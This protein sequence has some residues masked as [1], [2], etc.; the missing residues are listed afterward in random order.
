LITYDAQDPYVYE[1]TLMGENLHV[2]NVEIESNEQRNKEI[3]L[4][5]VKT[6][7]NLR[8]GIQRC[9]ID[10]ERLIKSQ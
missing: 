8:M 5:T 9:I 2:R 7:R 6:M 4:D 10:N 1:E 3:S